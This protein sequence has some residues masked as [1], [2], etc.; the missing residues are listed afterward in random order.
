MNLE[1]WGYALAEGSYGF[2]KGKVEG[3]Q[4]NHTRPIMSVLECADW[5]QRRDFS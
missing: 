4:Q 5:A 3:K 2:E 1:Y